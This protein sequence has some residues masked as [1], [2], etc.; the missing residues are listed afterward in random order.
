MARASRLSK[1]DQPAM[2]VLR[3]AAWGVGFGL[4]GYAAA[5]GWN[6]LRFGKAG[7]QWPRGSSLDAF[8]PQFDVVEHHEVEVAAPV[9]H[10]FAA[11]ER[12][13]LLDSITIRS[14]IRTRELVSGAHSQKRPEH[15]PFLEW[16]ESLG[17]G[18]LAEI[19]GRE[20]VMGA[21]TQ[22][23]YGDVVFRALPGGAFRA[24]GDPDFVKIVWA[25]RAEAMESN[26]TRVST[27]TRAVAT[28]SGA[29]SKFRRY[30]SLVSPGVVL[31]RIAALRLIRKNAERYS[32]SKQSP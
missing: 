14:L 1:S 21:V 20:V 30:W 26:R 23:W 10:V 7:R 25:V 5:V 31:I 22:P 24:F 32:R 8:L 18:L 17:W 29:R 3:G 6:W 27:E 13:D 9:E 2:R 28:D 11:V 16:M 15:R 4:A 19:P 12:L